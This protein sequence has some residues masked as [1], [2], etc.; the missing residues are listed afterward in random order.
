MLKVCESEYFR[1]DSGVRQLCI[2]SH[3]LFK[4]Y[5]KEVKM[6]MWRRGVRFHEEEKEGRLSGLL[7]TDDLVLCGDSKKNL[8]AKVRRFVEVCRRRGL[9]VNAGKSKVI[10]LGGEEGSE[11]LRG[12]R[13]VNIS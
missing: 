2:M 10:L 9:K 4:V 1:I 8:M 13:R 7:Y 12:G 3:W 5:M 6:G 11:I